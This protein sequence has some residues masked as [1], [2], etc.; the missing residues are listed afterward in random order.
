MYVRFRTSYYEI[1]CENH[2]KTLLDMKNFFH[3]YT[4]VIIDCSQQNIKSDTVDVWLEL[5]FKENV[6]TNITCYYFIIHDRV[7][8][9]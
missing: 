5:E 2:V 4:H 1:P 7:I 8:E 9:K 6:P 3:G